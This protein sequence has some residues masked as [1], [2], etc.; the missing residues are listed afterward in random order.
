[1]KFDIDLSWTDTS[2]GTNFESM[3]EG[4]SGI[5]DASWLNITTSAVNVIE[6]FSNCTRLNKYPTMDLTNC[7]SLQATFST[8]RQMIEPPTLNNASGITNCM[9]TFQNCHNL[10]K[11]VPSSVLSGQLTSVR[12]MYYNCYN[13]ESVPA[14]DLS[15]IVAYPNSYRFCYIASG[16][17]ESLV[18]THKSQTSYANCGLSRTAIVDIFNNLQTNADGRT[19]Y[20]GSN[21]GSPQLTAADLLI[22]TNKG[23][24]VSS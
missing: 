5:T 23:W 22:A 16:L 6:L 15:A 13:I 14:Y 18:T 8:N 11:A 2:S 17:K 21:P 19:I 3:F 24:T 1:M 4:N 7:T 9:Q 10:K 12:E 20:V